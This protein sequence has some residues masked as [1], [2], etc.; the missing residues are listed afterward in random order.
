MTEINYVIFGVICM[1]QI[2]I[3][4]VEDAI[5]HQHIFKHIL[6]ENRSNVCVDIAETGEEFVAQAKDTGIDC[7]LVDFNLPD[8]SAGELL[9][10]ASVAIGDRPVIVMSA[11][12]DQAIVVE[13]FRHGGCDFVSKDQAVEGDYLWQRIES[14]IATHQEKREGDHGK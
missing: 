6:T 4:L 7:F 10:R 12:N 11:S 9:E 14:A 1:Q 8:G 2:R 13:S 5:E 3:L